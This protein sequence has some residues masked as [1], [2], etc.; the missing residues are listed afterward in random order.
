VPKETRTHLLHEFLAVIGVAL[1]AE[2]N[3]FDI[4]ERGGS[5]ARTRWWR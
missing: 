5:R 3:V 2:A 4:V 1:N